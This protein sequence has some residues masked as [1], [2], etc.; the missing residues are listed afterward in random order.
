VES[1]PRLRGPAVKVIRTEGV[2]YFSDIVV[3]PIKATKKGIGA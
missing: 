1:E 3:E 2:V